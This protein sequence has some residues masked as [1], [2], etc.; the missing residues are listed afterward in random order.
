ME[1]GDITV[2]IP[3]DSVYVCN[4]VLCRSVIQKPMGICGWSESEYVN[5]MDS[6]DPSAQKSMIAKCCDVYL[7]ALEASGA[8]E[9]CLEH[10]TLRKLLLDWD[11]L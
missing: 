8:K 1:L 5:W 9:S 7:Q 2:F 4:H 10:P 3:I 11:T 6:V